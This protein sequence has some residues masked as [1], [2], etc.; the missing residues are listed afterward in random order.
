MWLE[1]TSGSCLSTWRSTIIAA[2]ALLACGCGGARASDSALAEDDIR[3]NGRRS[4][5]RSNA[6]GT[7]AEPGEGSEPGERRLPT[8][9]E[10]R[11]LSRLFVITERLRHL[12]FQQ[13][14]ARGGTRPDRDRALRTFE[15]G[16]GGHCD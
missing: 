4:D 3:L 10:T 1:T 8:A 13:G 5:H 12:A 9:E 2:G 16:G 14:G 6:S 15:A 11:I 7:Y